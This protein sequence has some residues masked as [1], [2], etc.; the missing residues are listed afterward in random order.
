MMAFILSFMLLAGTLSDS[1]P[2]PK[3]SQSSVM[4]VKVDVKSGS[5]PLHEFERSVLAN[6]QEREFQIGYKEIFISFPAESE[7]ITMRD[8][9]RD[10]T[11]P[12]CSCYL[13]TDIVQIDEHTGKVTIHYLLT[14]QG[15]EKHSST[16]LQS[17]TIVYL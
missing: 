9:N 6:S 5:I 4:E 17:V 7:I 14:H 13:T 3:R 12:T 11:V 15:T 16:P 8:P 2:E 10:H 1:D